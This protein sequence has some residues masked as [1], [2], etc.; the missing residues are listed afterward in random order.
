MGDSSNNTMQPNAISIGEE[1]TGTGGAYAPQPYWTNNRW[2]DTAL[3]GYYQNR[4]EDYRI[5]MNPPYAGWGINQGP[6]QTSN[7]GTWYADCG[8]AGPCS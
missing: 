2:V 8:V 6:P 7:G 5:V 3:F 1:L 4:W